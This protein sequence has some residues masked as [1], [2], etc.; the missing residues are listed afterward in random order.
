MKKINLL[1]SLLPLAAIA[2]GASTAQAETLHFP[3]NP[4]LSPDG[5]DIYFSYR[6]TVSC[7]R[8]RPTS[9]ATTMSTSCR[10]QAVR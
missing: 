7:W 1:L 4:S 6:R 9:T 5:K 2:A 10:L 8:S 3:Y